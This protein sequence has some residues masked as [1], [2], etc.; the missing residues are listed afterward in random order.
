MKRLFSLMAAMLFTAAVS[1]QD[2]SAMY[3]GA[4]TTQDFL[5]QN[6]RYASTPDPNFHIYIC[7]GQSNMEGAA[8][9]E[10]QDY[11]WDNPRFLLMA[12][13][14]F[15]ANQGNYRGEGRKKYEWSV[16]VPP[17][18]RAWSGLTPADYFGR[19]MVENT[20]D[21]IKIGVIHVAIGG[22][23]IEHLFKEYD[24]QTVKNEPDWFKGIMAGYD[25]LPYMRVLDCA[26]RAS[27]QGVIKG[28]LLHQGC[29]NTGDKLWPAKV[30]KVY[31]DLLSDLHLNA[32]D[33]PIIAGEVVA[34][35][36]GGVCASMNPIIRTLPE[37]I[38][39][40]AWVSADGCPC[41]PD[42]LHFNAEGYREIGR[43]YAAKMLEF[44]NNK[45]PA[46]PA[47]PD[48]VRKPAQKQGKIETFDYTVEKDGQKLQKHAQ[49]YL[50]YGYNPKDKK[51]R[52]NVLYL[53]HGG[54]DNIT[55]FIESREDWLPLR[56]I[57]DNMIA[58]GKMKPIIVVAPTF[59]DNDGKEGNPRM[60]AAT[61]ATRVFHKELQ[62][63]LI[64]TVEK[65]YNTYL[66]K[67]P[68]LKEIEA[69]RSHRAYGGFSMGALST[70]YQLAYGL[71][72]VS[73]Y[74]PLSGDVWLFDEKGN[75]KDF[76]EVAKWL[77]DQVSAS[78]YANDFRVFGY[79]GTDDI[80]YQP[81]TNL[82]KALQKYAPAFKYG[83]PD[84]PGVNLSFALR[85]G[86]RHYY[87]H[88]N[89]YLY[90]AL[91]MLFK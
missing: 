68:T 8:K 84:Q 64:P 34:E 6:K 33:C 10:E 14:D 32:E 2:A 66:T 74:I 69:T 56:H 25:N 1:A 19:T 5:S 72:V 13:Q 57:L 20:P 29:T 91:P 51:T 38:P 23:G 47:I 49:V 62:N 52:Y 85:E 17:L 75:R 48:A 40:S 35:M 18:C 42:H 39:T 61:E 7:I 41:G 90:F 80:A 58:E 16:A 43:R 12:S 21:S 28:I 87:G 65:A 54:G 81:E 37:T 36:Y 11:A 63:F 31:E 67:K 79:T 53:M 15:P 89:E 60:E 88:V 27:H 77:N 83:L 59:Y 4:K 44:E 3:G 24:P 78:P 82:V 9:P 46:I 26:L 22:C 86:G 73:T 45:I 30:K 70:W 50:P 76:P 55:S 71:N